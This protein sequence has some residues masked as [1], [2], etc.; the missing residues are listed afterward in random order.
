M[1]A[2]AI[3]LA[4]VLVASR[5]EATLY[6]PMDEATLAAASAAIVTGTVTATQPRRIGTRIVTETTV[7]VDRVYKG[8][9]DGMTVTVTT[10]GGQVDDE[11]AVVFGAPSFVPDETVL[12][13]LQASP[14]GEVRTTALALGA[15]HL[16]AAVDGT[17]LATRMVPTR[18]TRRLDEIAATAQALGDP[19]SALGT[20]ADASDT[21][22][23]AEFTFLGSPP[24]RWFQ[25]D[26]GQTVRYAVA[27]A[28]VQLGVA[29]SNDVVDAALAAWTD[30]PTA[31][32]VLERGGSASTGP[33]VAGG[34]CDGK[35]VVQFNDPESE[36]GSLNNC[37]GILAVGGFCTKGTTGVFNGQTFGRISE[38]DLTVNN[39]LADCFPRRSDYEEIVTHEIGHTIGLGHSSENP[40][41]PDPVLRD[42]T[43]YFLAHLD[44]RGASLRSDDVAG[45]SF[46]YKIENDPNDLDGDGVT[47]DAD[48]CPNTPAGERVD[49]TGCACGEAGHVT[50][51][52]GL[53]CTLDGCN[54]AVGRCD[55]T[56][57]D[58]THGDPCLTGSCDEQSGC[59]TANVTGDAAVLC[60]YRRIYPPAACGSERV[61]R[62]V[63]KLLRR[64]A[65]LA[66][67]GLMRDKPR[68]LR[69]ADRRLARAHK[70]IDR[71]AQRRRKPQGPVCANALVAL[72]DEARARLP[73]QR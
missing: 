47:N 51:D 62:V 2:V 42:A 12:L 8:A 9:I 67:R 65:R 19:G 49:T 31:S 64:A 41:E 20:G 7:A 63:R 68:L 1:R 3:L 69:A 70:A 4:A 27:N 22:V 66:E 50:C 39:G 61:P 30:V 18:E 48:V 72:I 52:D 59:M 15:Y 28:D 35:S 33:S 34:H 26:T 36:I 29:V 58:C 53:V 38:G 17:V 23:T 14:R 37:T 40:N 11:R 60:V 6:V 56:P 54:S 10:P 71:A 5:S 25:A 21:S 16:E 32:I 55:P 45:V 57:I 44:G 13:F 43:M 73:L 46:I 24:G